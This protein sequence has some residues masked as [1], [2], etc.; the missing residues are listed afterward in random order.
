MLRSIDRRLP[1]GST[2]TSR[3]LYPLVAALA[4]A[5]TG[6]SGC[7]PIVGAE[8]REGLTRCGE[9]CVDLQSDPQHCGACNNACAAGQACV[10]GMCTFDFD[11]GPRDGD[12][13]D[14]ELR[15]GEPEDTLFIFDGDYPDGYLHDGQLPD[16]QLPDGQLPDGSVSCDDCELPNLCCAGRCVDPLTDHAHCGGCG[17]ACDVSET[18]EDGSCEPICDPPTTYCGG[19]CV[20]LDTDPD[21]CGRCNNRCP[22]GLCADGR[23]VG[24]PPGHVVL[25]GHSYQVSRAVIRRVLGNAVWLATLPP[26]EPALDVLVYEGDA[27]T[28]SRNNAT[29]AINESAAGRTWRR[30]VFSDVEE[31]EAG[32]PDAEVVLIHAR[33]NATDAA[34]MALG[35]EWGPALVAFVERGGVVVVLDA[36]GSHG[37]TWQIPAAAGLLDVGGRTTI[38]TPTLDVVEPG[39]A[40][41][42]GLPGQYRAELAS[43]HFDNAGGAV[44]VVAHEGAPVVV[45]RVVP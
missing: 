14:G 41:A 38:G 16:G 2:E 25:I 45:H 32:L 21:H 11:G 40:V 27:S 15:D 19:D 35:A 39:D 17:M 22:T 26:V 12:V 18:C 30:T 31:L 23:C 8:C 3:A 37:G 20:L 4:L 10:A 36:G 13:L 33:G 42:T 43:A 34:L 6:C 24:T 1:R 28:A 5:L 7:S 29:T 44:T 9:L